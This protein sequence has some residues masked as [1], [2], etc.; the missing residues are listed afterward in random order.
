[1]EFLTFFV[2]FP[3]PIPT[4]FMLS[5]CEY[6]KCASTYVHSHVSI[7]KRFPCTYFWIL[8]AQFFPSVSVFSPSRQP[9]DCSSLSNFKHFYD[10]NCIKVDCSV[11]TQFLHC[12]NCVQ[13]AA[14]HL[15]R[16]PALCNDSATFF[17]IKVFLIEFVNF[18]S[19]ND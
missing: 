7:Y 3:E 12:V 8:N 2:P 16:P 4:M 19:P 10:Q 11:S 6:S 18:F 1:M 14:K 15:R 9:L 5:A 13:I 17:P